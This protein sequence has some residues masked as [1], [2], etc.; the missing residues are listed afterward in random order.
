MPALFVD[1]RHARPAFTLIEMLTS[2]GVL[3]VLVAI[4]GPALAAAREESRSTAC[5]SNLRQ[6]FLAAR[7]YADANRGWGPALGEPYTRTPNWAI[8]VQKYAGVRGVHGDRMFSPES[9][10][11]CPTIQSHYAEEM[12]RTYAT[13]VTG[14]AGRPEDPDNYDEPNHP[15]HVH[16]DQIAH[17]AQLP[18]S[19]D[20]AR[21][22]VISDGPPAPR[23]ASVID[24]REESHREKRIGWFHSNRKAFNA[25]M[26]DGSGGA[27]RKLPIEWQR[28]LP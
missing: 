28:A 17:P 19:M 21:T 26:Y 14:H 24:F 10:L 7:M 20:S 1:Q 16:V 27:W 11:V 12:T 4:L 15:A 3:A 22:S 9:V 23:T 6:I 25:G 13:N 8:V 2:V 5:R 18:I